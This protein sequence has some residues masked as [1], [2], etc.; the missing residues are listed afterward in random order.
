MVKKY[1]IPNAQVRD[2]DAQIEETFD[3]REGVVLDSYI[4]VAKSGRLF[5]V[6]DTYETC[7]TSGYTL[8]TATCKRDEK[9]LWDIWQEFTD[10]YD[11][12][13]EEVEG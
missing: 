9:K 10:K 2:I 11:E 6:I 5:V 12:E 3:C 7:W 8:Y 1:Y 13:C 4:A